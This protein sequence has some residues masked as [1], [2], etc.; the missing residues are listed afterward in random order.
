MPSRNITL[1]L[2]LLSGER[3]STRSPSA[4]PSFSAA[5]SFITTLPWPMTLSATSLMSWMPTLLPQE[6]C[7]LR[8]VTSQNG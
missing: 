8:E 7:M 1:P 3:T 6:Y 4:M 5:P 2:V